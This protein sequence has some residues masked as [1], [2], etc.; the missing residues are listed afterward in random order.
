[1]MEQSLS[2]ARIKTGVIDVGGGLRGIYAAG[3][4]DY[5]IEKGIRF[6]FGIGVSAGSANLASFAAGQKGRNYMFY[7]EYSFRKKY[8]SIKNFIDKRSYIDLDY[9]YGIL[10]NSDGEN[11][12]DYNAL[13]RNP[14]ELYVVATNAHSGK[15]KY[16]EKKDMRQNDYNI[17][18]ASCTIPFVCPPYCVQGDLYFD[19]GLSDPVPVEKAF[20]LGCDRLVVILT[21]P[22]AQI[23]TSKNDEKL[24][25]LIRRRY[26]QSAKSLCSRAQKYNESVEMAKQYEK[27]GKVL[28]VSPE[29]TC[30]VDTLTKKKT[31]L[32]QLYQ[33]G[34]RDG[35]KINVFLRNRF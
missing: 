16:F 21:K 33:K 31:A 13:V 22:A 19:G 15:A 20:S 26:P 27:Q 6:D 17:L 29:D 10:S 11:P 3:V 35:E 24:A 5:C 2:N 30:G 1:M 7:S 28:I 9:V 23:R 25:M 14:M 4:L 18:K 34:Y 32:H 12:L 8:M